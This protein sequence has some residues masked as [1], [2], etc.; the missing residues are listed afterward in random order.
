MAGIDAFPGF[1]KNNTQYWALF[2]TKTNQGRFFFSLGLIP[3]VEPKILQLSI[4]WH[5]S[6]LRNYGSSRSF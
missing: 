6:G 2:S 5:K 1:Y 4:K 3:Y